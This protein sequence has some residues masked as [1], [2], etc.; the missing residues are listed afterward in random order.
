M[1]FVVWGE[2]NIIG[3]F[4]FPHFAGVQGNVCLGFLVAGNVT[5]GVA[6]VIPVCFCGQPFGVEFVMQW[7]GSIFECR[8]FLQ[9]VD[10]SGEFAR[11]QG[12]LLE[13]W[14]L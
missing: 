14:E 6:K 9:L 7:V 8:V 1:P 13:D 5:V 2:E 10:I 11:V 12:V 3:I 4:R